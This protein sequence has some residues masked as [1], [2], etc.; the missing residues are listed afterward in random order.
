MDGLERG[1][2]EMEKMTL[3]DELK[4]AIMAKQ[5][6]FAADDFYHI[7]TAR[8]MDRS[9]I[10]KAIRLL[11]DDFCIKLVG[12][13]GNDAGRDLLCYEVVEGAKVVVKERRRRNP[14]KAIVNGQKFHPNENWWNKIKVHPVMTA[15]NNLDVVMRG[16][17]DEK[18]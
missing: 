2:G 11:R 12:H 16:W 13:R 5:G 3:I 4:Q 17:S 1:D 14:R 9:A 6:K 10:S 7:I 8:G 15:Q 18:P